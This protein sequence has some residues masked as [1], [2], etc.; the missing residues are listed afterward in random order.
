[1]C[2]HLLSANLGKD[3]NSEV[4]LTSTNSEQVYVWET[5]INRPLVPRGVV[6]AGLHSRI[7][8]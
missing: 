5:W 7:R 8:L 4:S 1:M 3:G 2:K 6:I